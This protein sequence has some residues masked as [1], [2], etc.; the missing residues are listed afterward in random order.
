MAYKYISTNGNEYVLIEA[1][2]KL[3]GGQKANVFYFVLPDTEAAKKHKLAEKMPD[4]YE[5][6]EINRN[7]YPLVHKVNR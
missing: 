6:K 4:G 1:N 3:K 7:G 2:V 5:V